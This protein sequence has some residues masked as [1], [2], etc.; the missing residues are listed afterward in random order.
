MFFLGFVG[1]V[2]AWLRGQLIGLAQGSLK[3]SLKFGNISL[4][5]ASVV[6]KID[7]TKVNLV[8]KPENKHC[9]L[10][11]HIAPLDA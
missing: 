4:K 11:K 7:H 1:E 2:M 6:G 9:F 8:K 3:K 5:Y 10:H